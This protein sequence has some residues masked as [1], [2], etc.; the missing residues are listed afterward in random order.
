MLHAIARILNI[1]L[2]E[3]TRPC[4]HGSVFA[5]TTLASKVRG[6]KQRTTTATEDGW[7]EDKHELPIPIRVND[8]SIV[9]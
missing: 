9:P 3:K 1:T 6:R 4:G 8:M 7:P 5:K 2:V